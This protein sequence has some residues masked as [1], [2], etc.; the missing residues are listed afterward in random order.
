[1]WELEYAVNRRQNARHK[2]FL[3]WKI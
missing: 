1:M 2:C 3:V